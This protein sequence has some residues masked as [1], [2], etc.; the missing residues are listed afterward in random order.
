VPADVASNLTAA[1]R[2][3]HQRSVFEIKCVDHGR[4]IVGITVHIVPGGGLA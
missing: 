1:G 4:Q 3:P 2:V